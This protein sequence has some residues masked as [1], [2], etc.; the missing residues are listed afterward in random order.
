MKAKASKAKR[1]ALEREQ[2]EKAEEEGSFGDELLD[3]DEEVQKTKKNDGGGISEG[4]GGSLNPHDKIRFDLARLG[5]SHSEIDTAL[6]EMWNM[7]LKYDEFDSVLSYLNTR[8]PPAPIPDASIPDKEEKFVAVEQVYEEKQTLANTE[9]PKMED[10]PAL[11][12]EPS[13]APPSVEQQ[14]AMDNVAPKISAVEDVVSSESAGTK[15]RPRNGQQQQQQPPPAAAAAPRGL[16]EKLDMVSNHESLS[17][18]VFALTEWVVRVATADEIAE[19]CNGQTTRALPNVICRAILEADGESTIGA[20]LDLVGAVLRSSGMPPTSISSAAKALGAVILRARIVVSS[21]SVTS[22]ELPSAVALGAANFVSSTLS[23]TASVTRLSSDDTE[24]T[25]RKLEGEIDEL[26]TAVAAAAATANGGEP[27]IVDLMTKRDQHKISAEKSSTVLELGVLLANRGAVPSGDI[28][29]SL[30]KQDDEEIGRSKLMASLLGDQ[31]AVIMANRAEYEAIKMRVD[32]A[33][34]M[35]YSQREG[36]AAELGVYRSERDAVAQ[37]MA[38]LRLELGRL[39]QQE[40][41]L[42]AK[43]LVVEEKM[44]S[45]DGSSAV[46]DLETKLDGRSEHVKAGDEVQEVAIK[47]QAFEFALFEASNAAVRAAST[48][49]SSGAALVSMTQEELGNKFGSYLERMKNY[50][51]TEAECVEFMLAR[52][53]KLESGIPDLQRE[54]EECAALKMTTNVTQMTQTLN[55]TRSHIADDNGV[56]EALRGEATA[57]KA[58]LLSSLEKFN[59]LMGGVLTP[60]N[61]SLLRDIMDAMS[62]IGVDMGGELGM[63]VRA[64]GSNGSMDSYYGHNTYTTNATSNNNNNNDLGINVGMPE[65]AQNVGG[66]PLMPASAMSQSS[67]PAAPVVSAQGGATA[68]TTARELPSEPVVPKLSW[69]IAAGG[70]KVQAKSLRDIQKEEMSA[71]GGR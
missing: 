17:D 70:P 19:F 62:R 55:E 23:Q 22:M 6:E 24:E 29:A 38:E 1:E 53:K 64:V 57:M 25:L 26:T 33:K 43:V 54:I 20:I 44:A 48:K 35:S 42:S 28:A 11:T 49:R 60:K 63:Y 18:A 59:S 37:R 39:E 10:P 36:L 9:V 51:A 14:V 5:F 31:Y 21:N 34:S 16:G 27:T 47:L 7:Q 52:A 61:S 3:E 45:L 15:K 58:D 46:Q 32:E 12:E 4:G 41:N 66:G 68:T 50:F 40:A 69:A 30:L 2:R 8:E 67:V 71:K 56:A 13:S 65:N